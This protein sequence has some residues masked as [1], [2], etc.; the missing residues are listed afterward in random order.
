MPYQF[1]FDLTKVSKLLFREIAKIT[2]SK[3]VHKRMGEVAR[4]LLE[5]FKI[6]EITGLNVS[7]ALALLEDL[8]DI[9]LR[10]LLE[11]EKFLKAKKRALLLPHCSRKYMDGR[12]KAKFD[13]SIPSYI[14]SHCS[15]DCLINRSIL[16]A[17]EKGYDVYILP[18]SSCIGHILKMGYEAVVGVACSEEIKQANPLLER[19]GVA[20]QAIPLV[21]NGCANTLFNIQT[22]KEVL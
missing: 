17:S 12:C 15:Q 8:I 1:N 4:S 16:L 13:P 11:R 21:K 5:R 3:K 22:L 10:N 14:C 20:G 6:H 9:Q 2:Y 7:D 18:G 19:L